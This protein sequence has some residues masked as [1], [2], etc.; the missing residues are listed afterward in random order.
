SQCALFHEDNF[1]V[2]IP[3]GRQIAVVGKVNKPWT[4]AFLF[5]AAEKWQQVV[6]VQMHFERFV[7]RAIT[8]LEFF[9]NGRFSRESKTRWQPIHMTD[10]LITDRPSLNHTRPAD[11]AWNPE[12]AF[13]VRVF[14]TS[15]RSHRSIRP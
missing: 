4:R 14:F 8:L 6:S 10:N 11:Y 15:E 5:P 2:V 1:E 12:S 13:P 3:H 9:C 7:T